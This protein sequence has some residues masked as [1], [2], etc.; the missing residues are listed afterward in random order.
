MSVR[1]V[2]LWLIGLSLLALHVGAALL[3]Y[4]LL[5]LLVSNPPD[6]LTAVAVVGVFTVASAYLSY[7][8]G[9][10]QLLAGLDARELG[11]RDAPGFFRRLDDLSERMAVD[12]P[13]VFVADL[14]APNAFALGGVRSGALVVDVSL[15]RLLSPAER[16]AIVAHELAHL[17]G[18]DAFVQTLSYSAMRT[19]VGLIL[20]PLTP[21][22]LLI[23]GVARALAW[24][25]GRPSEWSRSPLFALYAWVSLGVTVLAVALTA[26]IRAH[27]RRREYRADDRAVEVTGDPLALARALRTIQR[28]TER[29]R[30]LL[31]TLY[32]SGDED[33]VLTRLLSTH[34]PM[35][36]RVERLLERA[37]GPR[38]VRIRTAD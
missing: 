37:D 7:R 11:P 26:L 23:T 21:V 13:R 17:E 8:F 4:L 15:F 12:R 3:A 1:R 34:P 22:L 18:Y 20:L 6:L 29:K 35:D 31:S 25:R 30:G 14:N 10:T 16:T 38:R 33:G 9:T 5:D 36:D 2:L 24:M 32:V 28:A 27:S 19:L